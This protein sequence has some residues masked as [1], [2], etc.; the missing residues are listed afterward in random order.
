MRLGKSSRVYLRGLELG[1]ANEIKVIQAKTS[2]IHKGS[3][4]VHRDM[5]NGCCVHVSEGRLHKRGLPEG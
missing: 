4:G 2:E 5:R 3:M 1:Y